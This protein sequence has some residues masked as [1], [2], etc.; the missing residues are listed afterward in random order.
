ME[1]LLERQENEINVL[2]SIYPNDFVDLREDVKLNA[3]K[4]NNL[5]R[6]T[7]YPQKSQSQDNREHYV[8]V[9]LR[10]KIRQNYPNE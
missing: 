4:T 10:L 9:D 5:V 6:I 8:Q 1:D 2:K 7:L 3:N